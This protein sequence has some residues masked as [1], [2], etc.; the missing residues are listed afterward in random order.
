MK[1][2]HPHYA[3]L[4]LASERRK[5]I[6]HGVSR[7][8]GQVGESAP[9]GRQTRRNTLSPIRILSPLPGLGSC[10]TLTHG[11]LSSDALRGYRR[12]IT[13]VSSVQPSPH[14]RVLE[15]WTL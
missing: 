8:I 1:A 10:M 13:W 6:A 12:C 14:G 15:F 5:I 4:A 2:Y 9:E 7:G 3:P 11:W